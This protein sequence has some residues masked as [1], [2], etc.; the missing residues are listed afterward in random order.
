MA[1]WTGSLRLHVGIMMGA[2][3]AQWDIQDDANCASLHVSI[4]QR[5]DAGLYGF[6][7]MLS[8][9]PL[10]SWPAAS[11]PAFRSPPG[12]PARD[13]RSWP[14]VPFPAGVRAALPSL[15]PGDRG[16]TRFAFSAGLRA[17]CR[18][19]SRGVSCRAR[20]GFLRWLLCGGVA[21]LLVGGGAVAI[22]FG[23][24]DVCAVAEGS[25]LRVPALMRQQSKGR[26]DEGQRFRPSFP[27]AGTSLSSHLRV[28]PSLD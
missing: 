15:W 4:R 23:S 11:A 26:V 18:S 25:W 20:M 22:G 8:H 27:G 10:P 2:W 7:S 24:F 6:R 21:G 1:S 19:L 17:G 12:S 5:S 16:C 13:G 28:P 9:P 3:C 14:A